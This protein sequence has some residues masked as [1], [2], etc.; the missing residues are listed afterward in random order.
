MIHIPSGLA[1]RPKPAQAA[2]QRYSVRRRESTLGDGPMVSAPLHYRLSQ[3][4]EMVNDV[5]L[6]VKTATPPPPDFSDPRVRIRIYDST[7][8]GGLLQG[9]QPNYLLVFEI[10][11]LQNI[12]H[13]IGH[14]CQIL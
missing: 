7:G 12:L 8:I 11:I 6:R 14:S 13:F 1:R 5:V 9:N 10:Q 3:V 2:A 4:H